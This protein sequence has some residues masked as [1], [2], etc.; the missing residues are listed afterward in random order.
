MSSPIRPPF[1]AATAAEKLPAGQAAHEA[2]DDPPVAL[3]NVPAGHS[4]HVSSS[5]APVA[6]EKRPAA[7]SEQVRFD[8][9]PGEKL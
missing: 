4:A 7:Q 6:A 1:T 3:L 8:V 2:L 9:A 5:V